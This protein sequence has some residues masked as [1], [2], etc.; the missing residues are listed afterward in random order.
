MVHFQGIWRPG[1]V[2]EKDKDGTLFCMAH[3]MTTCWFKNEDV[4]PIDRRVGTGYA[5]LE[6]LESAATAFAAAQY[7]TGQNAGVKH[8]SGMAK[9]SSE[10]L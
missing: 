3:D 4:V 1:R 5:T 7:V 9:R 10:A 2:A 6:L 8:A